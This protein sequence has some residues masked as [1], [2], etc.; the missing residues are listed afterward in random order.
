MLPNKNQITNPKVG[1]TSFIF[2]WFWP[3]ERVIGLAGI[4]DDVS[5][6][7]RI[8]T[9]I[10]PFVTAMAVGAFLVYLYAAWDGLKVKSFLLIVFE[11]IGPLVVLLLI[12]AA[13]AFGLWSLGSWLDSRNTGE[14]VNPDLLES[15]WQ[16]IE[17]QC[18]MQALEA[19]SIGG[20]EMVNYEALR[21]DYFSNCM[22][23]E[24]FEFVPD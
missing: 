11:K 12:F 17:A 8:M 13:L 5:Q 3:A 19:V 2:C 10:A 15:E 14:W 21:R 23:V 1:L 22:I 24:G 9:A 20:T 6:W 18:E 4:F 16:R 7:A